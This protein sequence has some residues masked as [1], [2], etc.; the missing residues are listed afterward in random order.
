MGV[1]EM[2][3]WKLKHTTPDESG[4]PSSYF[5]RIHENEAASQP[6]YRQ[7]IS[8]HWMFARTMIDYSYTLTTH[9]VPGKVL[10]LVVCDSIYI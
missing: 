8:V 7:C 6:F 4:K 2:K 10:L 9:V 1:C 3:F 5:R